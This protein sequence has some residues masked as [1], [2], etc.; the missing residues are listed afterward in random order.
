MR[1]LNGSRGGHTTNLSRGHPGNTFD[2]LCWARR[3]LEARAFENV[4][5]RNAEV[6][7]REKHAFGVVNAGMHQGRRRKLV[8]REGDGSG[9]VGFERGVAVNSA[10]RARAA[11]G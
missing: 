3:L 5:R 4:R 6:P 1:S 7:G 11:A 8:G 10:V 2:W 9:V